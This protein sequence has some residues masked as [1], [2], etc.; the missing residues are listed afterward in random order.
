MARAAKGLEALEAAKEAMAKWPSR[1]PTAWPCADMEAMSIFLGE[2]ARLR[3]G[4]CI[5]MFKE[6]PSTLGRFTSLS[7]L[8]ASF[9]YSC[10]F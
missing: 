9:L 7:A 3:P 6:L 2:V 8:L 10:A 5:L 1:R 4:G